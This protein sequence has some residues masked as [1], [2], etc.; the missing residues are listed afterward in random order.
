MTSPRAG[1]PFLV[2]S[3]LVGNRKRICGVFSLSAALTRGEWYCRPGETSDW[4]GG[5][6]SPAV[7]FDVGERNG[8]AGRGDEHSGR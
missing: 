5:A 7:V 4:T 8:V 6:K 2:M 1:R 3:G